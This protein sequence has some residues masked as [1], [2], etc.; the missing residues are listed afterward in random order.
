MNFKIFDAHTHAFPDDLAFRTITHLSETSGNLSY[1]H[2]GTIGGLREYESKGGASGFLLLPIAT[3]P[4]QTRSVNFWAAQQG[5]NGCIAF[6][7]I[8]PDSGNIKGDL[9][10]VQSLGLPGLKL[11]PEYQEFFVDEKRMFPIYEDIFNRGL[12]IVFHAGDDLGFK[13]PFRGGPDRIARVAKA[14]P[15]G[16]IVAAHM[17]G[18][19]QY[20]MVFE[21]LCGL[22]NVWLDTSFAARE[23][24]REL[25]VKMVK[26]HGADRVLFAT[27]APWAE[28]ESSLKAVTDSG[29][30]E[31]EIKM[32]LWD[33]AV[34]L[35]G[36]F[37]VAQK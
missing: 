26:A 19:R 8:H 22:R 30:S 33:N 17:G 4:S 11:H 5:G 29:L 20:D 13:P 27:D 9:D 15:H 31:N 12:S 32:I 18:Y 16:K 3:K 37:Q 7:S 2:N 25:F 6:G 23:M 24:E 21:N 34:E 14:F 10:F 28:F 36:L 35:W 1:H